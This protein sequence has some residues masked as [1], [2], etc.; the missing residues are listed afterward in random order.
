VGITAPIRRDLSIRGRFAAVSYGPLPTP[1]VLGSPDLLRRIGEAFPCRFST[2]VDE[3]FCAS[4]AFARDSGLLQEPL[5]RVLSACDQASVP[6]T[7]T[8]L[9]CG[10]F[11][12]G[13]GAADVLSR[14]GKTYTFGIAPHG[15]HLEAR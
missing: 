7:M 13:D 5:E 11:A 2:T 3:F 1:S 12:M 4:R 10:V 15:F 8:M 14:F 9:G 6:A